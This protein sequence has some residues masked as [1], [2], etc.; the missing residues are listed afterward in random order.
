MRPTKPLAAVF[1]LSL[2]TFAGGA[3]A[4][5]KADEYSYHFDDDFM[6]GDTLGTTPLVILERKPAHH[7]MLLRP[8]AS[9]V[10]EMLK[11]IE[12]M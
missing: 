12:A 7:V 8:R 10:S 2:F 6:V 5:T 11:S 1:A 3:G 9:F 4:Q